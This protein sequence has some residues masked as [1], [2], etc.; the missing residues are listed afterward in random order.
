MAAENVGLDSQNAH[1][2]DV[3]EMRLGQLASHEMTST[4]ARVKGEA[5]EADLKCTDD[6]VGR[7]KD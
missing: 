5:L 2:R 6:E 7:L 1:S 3:E 4:T